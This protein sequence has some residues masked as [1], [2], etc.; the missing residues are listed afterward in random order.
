MVHLFT[1]TI[2]DDPHVMDGLLLDFV[3]NEEFQ[4]VVGEGKPSND[5]MAIT[6]NEANPEEEELHDISGFHVQKGIGL[7]TDEEDLSP[8]NEDDDLDHA[9]FMEVGYLSG[10]DDPEIR[11]ARHL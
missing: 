6:D 3:N 5:N 2:V 4:H 11:D 7:E 1:K 8:T 10:N 9:Y